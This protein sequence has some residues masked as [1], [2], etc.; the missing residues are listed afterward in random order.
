M[1]GLDD[2]AGEGWGADAELVLDDGQCVSVLVCV[3]VDNFGFV[4]FLYFFVCWGV[5][6]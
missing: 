3:C 5:G 6:V 2:G 1:D 4:C